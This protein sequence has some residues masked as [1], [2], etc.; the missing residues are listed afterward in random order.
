VY[1]GIEPQ[2]PP[3]KRHTSENI[4]NKCLNLFD[5]KIHETESAIKISFCDNS[6]I[7]NEAYM[8]TY[9]LIVDRSIQ[10]SPYLVFKSKPLKFKYT[11]TDE[12]IKNA[13][14]NNIKIKKNESTCVI[15]EPMERN[16]GAIGYLSNKEDLDVVSIVT[17]AGMVSYK[18][19]YIKM[20]SNMTI[21]KKSLRL[22]IK[23]KLSLN[24]ENHYAN[25]NNSSEKLSLA[26]LTFRKIQS[27]TAYMGYN[28]KSEF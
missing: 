18:G 6:S 5:K 25:Q 17:N 26:D 11:F 7:E 24:L 1:H 22:A 14:A 2:Q 16:T 8:T 3:M 13:L 19:A 21:F 15:L 23:N 27:W 20:L 12:D 4:K 9:G 28:S 10:D